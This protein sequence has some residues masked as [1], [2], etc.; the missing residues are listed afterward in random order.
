LNARIDELAKDPAHDGK[1]SPKSIRE[2]EV[3]VALE[4]SGK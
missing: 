4:Q 2:A 3:G 1:T